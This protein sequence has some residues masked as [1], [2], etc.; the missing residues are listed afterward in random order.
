MSSAVDIRDDGPMIVATVVLPGCTPDRALAAFTDPAVL[1]NWW[2]GNL[3][4]SLV[5][6]GEYTVDFP[7]IGATLTGHVL[8]YEPSRSLEFSWAW[9]DD[10]APP[11][12]VR[13][14][15]EP[16]ADQPSTLLVVEHGPHADDAPGRVAHAEHWAGWEY[17]LPQ[18]QLAAD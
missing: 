17:F 7:A 11:S 4:A 18:T 15:V 1:A 6:G 5:P 16:G 14:R 3:T 12:T 9:A 8:S 13:V 2:R 10:D